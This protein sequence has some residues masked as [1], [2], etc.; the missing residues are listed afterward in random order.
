MLYKYNFIINYK[1]NFF[2]IFLSNK[3][4]FYKNKSFCYSLFRRLIYGKRKKLKFT[5]IL[6][7]I[8]YFTM[9][10]TITGFIIY[11]L[12]DS[13]IQDSSNINSTISS[14]PISYI[15]VGII[16]GS[17]SYGFILIMGFINILLATFNKTFTRENKIILLSSLVSLL[18]II[19]YF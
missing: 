14:Y 7:K 11:S 13:H 16:F 9:Y 1:N 2:D 15:I 18:P 6:F 17:I 19:T 5:N 3:H 8:I 4:I 12:I 10:L